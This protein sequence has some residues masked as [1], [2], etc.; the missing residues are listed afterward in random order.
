MFGCSPETSWSDTHAPRGRAAF[1][2]PMERCRIAPALVTFPALSDNVV[3]ALV[4]ESKDTPTDTRM[5]APIAIAVRVDIRPDPCTAR[6]TGLAVD[7]AIA[8]FPI[9]SLMFISYPASHVTVFEREGISVPDATDGGFWREGVAVI[10]YSTL[11]ASAG[12]AGKKICP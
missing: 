9:L 6:R 8:V 7:L 5:M 3:D 1:N 10:Q 4:N 2:R 12:I 11:V